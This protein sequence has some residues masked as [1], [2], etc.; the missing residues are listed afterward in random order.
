MKSWIALAQNADMIFSLCR[1][2]PSAKK[3]TGISFIVFSMHSK[4]VSAC[5]MRTSDGGHEVN[6]VF[7]CAVDVPVDHLAGEENR[8]R[9]CAKRLLGDE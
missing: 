4:G 1:T 6:N 5:P 3:Q 7:F 9:D 8:G 2:D